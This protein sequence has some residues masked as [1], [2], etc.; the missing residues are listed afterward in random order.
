MVLLIIIPFLNGYFI[1]NINPTFSD[2]PKYIWVN[3]ITT[4]LFSRTLESWLLKGNHP[5]MA[6]Q[7]RLV[8]IWPFFKWRWTLLEISDQSDCRSVTPRFAIGSQGTHL[9]QT[10][11]DVPPV[12]IMG[13]FGSLVKQVVRWWTA[14]N[15]LFFFKNPNIMNVP[16]L[17]QEW[18][19]ISVLVNLIV[20][21][22]H[23]FSW[24]KS[25]EF[26][27]KFQ[28]PKRHLL[29]AVA[30]IKSRHYK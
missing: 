11:L 30:W 21:P 2:K 3:F 12:P 16:C 1:G 26:R 9:G 7:F 18:E 22:N 20:A 6:Q 24:K 5:Q 14:Q 17:R 23:V 27:W 25:D 8:N 29:F 28:V 19:S 4:S 10:P 13:G 15:R